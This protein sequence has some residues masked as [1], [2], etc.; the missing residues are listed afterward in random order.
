MAI[1]YQILFSLSLQNSFYTNSQ[2][3]DFEL[4]PTPPTQQKLNN[5]QSLMRSAGTGINVLVPTDGT[6]AGK[7]LLAKF[8]KTDFDFYFFLDLK[9]TRFTNFTDSGLPAM[10][11]AFFFNNLGA[12]VSSTGEL[13]EGG[14]PSAQQ[15]IKLYG[16][17]IAFPLLTATTEASKALTVIDTW[18]N[19]VYSD[20]LDVGIS[21]ATIDLR[22]EGEGWYSVALNNVNQGTFFA[23]ELNFQDRPFAIFQIANLAKDGQT[24]LMVN[25][26]RTLVKRDYSC[27]FT[28]RSTTWNYIVLDPNGQGYV[29]ESVAGQV[30]N[31]ENPKSLSIIDESDEVVCDFIGLTEMPGGTMGLNFKSKTELALQSRPP[32]RFKLISAEEDDLTDAQTL[33]DPLPAATIASLQVVIESNTIQYHSQIH[34]YV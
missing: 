23:T 20:E 31:N 17:Q 32:Q 21:T 28:A 19:V 10:G 22:G 14:I 11:N 27:T 24:G 15:E 34:I 5:G 9:N 2:G 16:L 7:P 25:P 18:G 6:R 13:L 30:V 29:P 4:R 1:S 3:L 26:D 8:P 12:N 33:I